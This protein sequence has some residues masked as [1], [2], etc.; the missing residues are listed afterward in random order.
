MKRLSVCLRMLLLLLSLT[1]LG[2]CYSHASR[3]PEFP[4]PEESSSQ[5]ETEAST[6]K[7]PTGKRV[8][9]TFDDGPRQN[10]DLT[11]LIID[12]LAK[13]NYHA[14]FFVLG[15]RIANGDEIRYMVQTGNEIGIHGY[16]HEFYYDECSE[17]TYHRELEQTKDKIIKYLPD[18]KVRLMRPIGGRI[19]SERLVTCSYSVIMWSVD[20][21]DYE[22]KYYA[23]ISD[24]DAQK[25]VDTIV[26]N[27]MS[28][29]Q[30]GDIILM[31]D[32]YESTYD[33]VKIILQRLHEEG[34]EVVTVSELLGESLQPGTEYHSIYN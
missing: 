12:E 31:H 18:Y 26:S 32:I 13:Y 33:A 4:F 6:E 17:E 8:A 15:N 11:R 20:S 1:L 23:G 7:A 2:G 16:T 25:R 24:E 14:T 22:N 10:A 28:D 21:L 5:S 29:V 19:T 3:P 9:L 34:Y 27:V 30:E